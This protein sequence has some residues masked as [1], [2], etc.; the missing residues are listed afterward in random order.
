LAYGPDRP[1]G[2]VAPV[3]GRFA[4]AADCQDGRRSKAPGTDNPICVIPAVAKRRAGISVCTLLLKPVMT[5]SRLKAG[6]AP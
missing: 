2:A 1:A 6:M 4:L 3:G 5:R